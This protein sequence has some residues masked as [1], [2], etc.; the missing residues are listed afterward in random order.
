MS[1]GKGH[2]ATCKCLP[3]N[4]THTHPP[5]PPPQNKYLRGVYLIQPVCPFVFVSICIS[6]YS[7]VYKLAILCRE[8]LQ[9]F[10]ATVLKVS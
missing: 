1:A 5:P 2:S 7:S 8:L 9:S 6:M 3:F 4:N 10:V